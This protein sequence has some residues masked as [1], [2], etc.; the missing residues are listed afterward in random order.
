MRY[1]N[2][3]TYHLTYFVIDVDI[4][5]NEI[6]RQYLRVNAQ[7]QLV[8]PQPPQD[9]QTKTPLFFPLVNLH[10]YLHLFCLNMQ[11]EIIYMQSTMVSKTRWL[12]QLKVQM[13]PTRNKL[14]LVYWKG[15]SPTAHWAHP[16]V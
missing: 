7:K 10:D 9:E 16:Q 14:V 4:S 13:D 5:L 2:N 15:G 12:E 11:L 8:P 1:I 3:G 6:Q